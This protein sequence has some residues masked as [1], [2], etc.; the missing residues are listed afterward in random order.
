MLEETKNSFF[1]A[2]VPPVEAIHGHVIASHGFAAV[3][4]AGRS[5]SG[6]GLHFGGNESQHAEE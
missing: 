6:R 4:R 3:N 5:G 1:T 2:A